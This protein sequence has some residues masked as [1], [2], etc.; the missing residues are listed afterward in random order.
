VAERK[1]PWWHNHQLR[2]TLK[3]YADAQSELGK[4]KAKVGERDKQYVRAAHEFDNG[5]SALCHGHYWRADNEFWDAFQIA[6]HIL[7]Q[8]RR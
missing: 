2:I 8:P 1:Q 5:K 7:K 4:A 6:R 3:M